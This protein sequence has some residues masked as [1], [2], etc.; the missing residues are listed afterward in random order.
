MSSFWN[1]F[2]QSATYAIQ[3]AR[4]L[5]EP[6][7]KSVIYNCINKIC[8]R[9]RETCSSHHKLIFS[10][11][12]TLIQLLCSSYKQMQTPFFTSIKEIK[13][14][15]PVIYYF[16]SAAC[17]W[18]AMWLGNPPDL[19]VGGGNWGWLSRFGLG[20]LNYSKSN[21]NVYIPLIDGEH[22]LLHLCHII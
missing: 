1:G 17:G 11:H 20:V 18:L 6:R 15:C 14:A 5:V 10:K 7:R 13:C 8:H 19:E 3:K 2:L 21:C 12:S 9:Y 22:I 4:L 16:N